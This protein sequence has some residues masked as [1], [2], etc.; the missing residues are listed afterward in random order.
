MP[1]MG[2][3]RSGVPLLVDAGV[4]LLVPAPS[5]D[6]F[7]ISVRNRLFYPDSAVSMLVPSAVCWFASLPVLASP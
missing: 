7:P 1:G 3:L 4:F 6:A 5:A 2:K